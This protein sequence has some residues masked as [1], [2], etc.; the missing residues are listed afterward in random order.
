[1][2]DEF[3]L[4]NLKLDVTKLLEFGFVR[5][6]KNFYYET[7]ILDSQFNLII[8]ITEDNTIISDVFELSTNDKF[9]LYYVVDSS[10]DYVGKIRSEYDRIIKNIKDKCFS[11]NVFKSEYAQLIIQYVKEKYND[12]LEYLWEKF[13]N[14]AVFRNKQ[15]QKWY[16]LLLTVSRNK[17]DGKGNEE[18]EILD[19]LL[20]PENIGK[21]ID[22][23]KYF[24]GYHMNKKH[25]VTI[26]LDKTVD[27]NKI[28]QLLD[29]SY[30]L[31]KR[32]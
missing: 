13:S 11:K 25:W 4:K 18:I 19:I 24:P 31:S 7:K 27:I 29:N 20:E 22:Y 26:K 3:S 12:D 23:K 17:I 28:Y 15:N 30:E 8:K 1:M 21:L 9:I 5:K 2:K 32:K 14:N 10:G 16:G 6:G